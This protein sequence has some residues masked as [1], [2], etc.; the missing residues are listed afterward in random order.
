MQTPPRTT[1]LLP[2]LILAGILFLLPLRA[3]GNPPPGNS[4]AAAPPAESPAAAPAEHGL[5]PE[6]Q[7]AAPAP[8]WNPEPASGAWVWR[9][10]LS[11][12]AVGG[13]MAGAFLGLRRMRN[14]LGGT[15]IPGGVRLVARLPL[16]RH[17]TV[18]LL[19]TA[20]E[21]LVLAGGVRGV[22]VLARQPNDPDPEPAAARPVPSFLQALRAGKRES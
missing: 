15:A 20:G 16:D 13:L 2:R 4:P 12:L 18:Y 10:L 21:T 17:N 22:R 3:P 11:L 8:A 6:R 1:A 7:P 5:W 9:Y 14:L 19:R